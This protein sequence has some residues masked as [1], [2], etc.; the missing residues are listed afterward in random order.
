MPKPRKTWRDLQIGDTLF[1]MH[2]QN[3]GIKMPFPEEWRVAHRIVVR[4]SG[5]SEMIDKMVR[6]NAIMPD[7]CIWYYT[8]KY[9]TVVDIT[10]ENITAAWS[11]DDR[12]FGL[13]IIHVRNP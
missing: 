3:Q 13:M 5:G 4:T 8:N 1:D 7:D 10:D 6:Q 11:Y 12:V 9:L 2:D